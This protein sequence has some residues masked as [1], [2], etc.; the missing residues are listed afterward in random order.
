MLASLDFR[1]SRDA[2]RAI[3]DD[4]AS[5]RDLADSVRERGYEQGALEPVA[6]RID[7]A[8][9]LIDDRAEQLADAATQPMA[10]QKEAELP[11]A[12]AA[13]QRLI[14]AAM[15]YLTRRPQRRDDDPEG[16]ADTD[17]VV[18]VTEVLGSAQADLRPY[19]PAADEDGAAKSGPQG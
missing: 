19:M 8:L 17:A 18:V 3:V 15:H 9:H 12:S 11:P 13:R 7:A 10:V 1:R 6:D 4:P 5:L 16:T 2:S 14:V